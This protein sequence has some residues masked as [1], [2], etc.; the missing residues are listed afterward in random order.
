M[1]S[2]KLLDNLYYGIHPSIVYPSFHVDYIIDLTEK[3]ENLSFTLKDNVQYFRY[4]IRD[5]KAPSL[6][7]LSKIVDSLLKLEGVIYIACKGGHGRSGMLAACV[8][9][10]ILNIEGIE[11]L[12]LVGNEWKK[13]RDMS[14]LSDKV[15]R[16]GSP[17]TRI[18]KQ[19]VKNYLS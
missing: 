14:F 3:K 8:I 12:E 11:A 5:C 16:L 7:T 13:Q 17:Q 10:N 19:I 4:P 1:S 9:G 2:V 15:K 6:E 18:Q